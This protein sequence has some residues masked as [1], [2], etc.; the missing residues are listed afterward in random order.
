MSVQAGSIGAAEA[1]E[2]EACARADVT[3]HGRLECIKGQHVLFSPSLKAIFSLNETAA[4][5]WRCLE[6][7][8]RPRDIAEEIARQGVSPAEARAHVDA[9]LDEWEKAGVVRPCPPEFAAGKGD[10]THHVGMAGITVAILYPPGMADWA[11]APFRHLEVT[12]ATPDVRLRLVEHRNRVRLFRD[13]VWVLSCTAE[14]L[15]TALKGQLLLEVLSGGAYELA[16]HAACLARG[17]RALLLCGNPGAGKTTL[18]LAL[19]DSGFDFAGDDVTLL[20]SGGR[21]IG[22][23]FA[24]AV[25]RGAWSVLASCCPEIL[26]APDY[27]RPDGMR[28]R[29]PAPRI[30]TPSPPRPVGWVVL[31]DRQA[32]VAAHLESLGPD[33]ALRGLLDGAFSTEGELTGTAFDVLARVIGSAETWRLTYS[34]LDDAVALLGEACG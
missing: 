31:L 2:A 17:D 14:E 6:D 34:R 29:Y 10:V 27:R 3:L 15:P 5:I 33:D 1:L 13:D 21:S 28:V 22:L 26:A 8:M 24:P 25:K 30:A 19:V 12:G 9:A 16:L 18:T 11:H 32:D 7:G 4:G 23:P 20:D